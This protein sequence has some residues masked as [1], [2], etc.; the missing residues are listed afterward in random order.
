MASPQNCCFLVCLLIL[1]F[2]YFLVVF[3]LKQTS[4]FLTVWKRCL[5]DASRKS[6]HLCK[7]IITTQRME[8]AGLLLSFLFLWPLFLLCS[9]LNMFTLSD[10][11]T[12][13]SCEPICKYSNIKGGGTEVCLFLLKLVFTQL[14]RLKKAWQTNQAD[15]SKAFSSANFLN[16][17][18]TN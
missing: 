16:N 9:I 4:K 12:L 1:S 11:R 18:I 13:K 6:T 15:I 8:A 2:C 3:K 17:M 7:I 14:V 5:A 10:S